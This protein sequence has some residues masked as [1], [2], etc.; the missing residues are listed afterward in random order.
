MPPR[1]TT[2]TGS[3]TFTLPSGSH[4]EMLIFLD[5][6]IIQV[7]FRDSLVKPMGGCSSVGRVQASQA[8]GRGFD[9]RCPL[10]LPGW[11]PG[12]CIDW[13]SGDALL[14]EKTAEAN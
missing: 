1:P 13:L 4:E 14:V 6:T 9:P 11:Q 3:I 7:I 8:W 2:G 10:Q 12:Y 5:K